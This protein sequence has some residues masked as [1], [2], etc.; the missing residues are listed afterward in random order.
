M[1]CQHCGFAASDPSITVCPF[2]NVPSHAAQ[3]AQ[4]AVWPPA[5]VLPLSD[6]SGKADLQKQRQTGIIMAIVPMA[7]VLAVSRFSNLLPVPYG[8][9]LLLAVLLGSLYP[10]FRGCAHWAE[11]KGYPRY[12][13]RLLGIL[14]WL[15]VLLLAIRQ[16]KTQVRA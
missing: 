8:T 14:G 5:P 15:G 9:G 6:Y 13:G 12:E 1:K 3:P 7:I 4:A 2:C 16:D 11:A 10:H